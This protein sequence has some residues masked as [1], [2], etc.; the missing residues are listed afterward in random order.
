MYVFDPPSVSSAHV[1][2]STTLLP[3]DLIESLI[4]ELATLTHRIGPLP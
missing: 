1:S 2:G 4:D 3:I